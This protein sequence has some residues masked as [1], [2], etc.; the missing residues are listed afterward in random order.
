MDIQPIRS[1]RA[2][3][4]PEINFLIVTRL[5]EGKWV[6]ENLTQLSDISFLF[7]YDEFSITSRKQY[8]KYKI[9]NIQY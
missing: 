2:I 6:F 7:V 3:F 9:E 5:F 1:K 8:V 4:T